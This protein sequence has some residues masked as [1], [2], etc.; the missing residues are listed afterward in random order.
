M[1]RPATRAA[2]LGA[3]CA[4][5]LA[6]AAAAG[7]ASDS[8]ATSFDA[9]WLRSSAR[10]DVFLIASARLAMARAVDPAVA[11]TADAVADAHLRLL[12]R[13]RALA[14]ALRVPLPHRADPVQTLQINQLSAAATDAAIFEP[15]FAQ[16]QEAAYR[17][18]VPDTAEA[19][20]GA[21][22]PAVRRLAKAMLPVLKRNLV[23][24][25]RLGQ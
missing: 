16:A 17:L 10:A 12:A 6:G 15:L 8:T 13:R 5:G 22:S 25:G 18:A 7:A 24:L 2:A 4:I 23:A 14:R 19:A 3:A 11:E 9:H 21:A 1:T 20:R